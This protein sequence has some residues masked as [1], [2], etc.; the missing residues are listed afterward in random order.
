MYSLSW[1]KESPAR[2]GIVPVA[3]T[4]QDPSLGTHSASA[5]ADG[6]RLHLLCCGILAQGVFSM[7]SADPI[8]PG[9]QQQLPAASATS[10]LL[11]VGRFICLLIQLGF[12]RRRRWCRWWDLSGGRGAWSLVGGEECPVVEKLRRHWRLRR[13]RW[14]GISGERREKSTA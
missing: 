6:R 1:R 14:R 12:R 9:I 11:F 8:R 4:A 5:S 7:V 2:F 13:Q 10:L 3:I